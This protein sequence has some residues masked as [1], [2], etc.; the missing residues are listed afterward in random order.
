M[1][2][3][4]EQERIE[5][6]TQL[7]I[8]VAVVRDHP[9]NTFNLYMLSDLH[10]G[11][12]DC[13]YP[14]LQKAIKM[15]EADKKA[16]VILGGDT[17]EAIPRGY[18]INE[19]GQHCSINTQI[20]RTVKEFERIKKKIV[21]LFKGNHNSMARGESIDSDFLIA[22]ALG[23]PYKTVPSMIHINTPTGIVKLAGGHGKSSGKNNDIEL[24]QI[25]K[26]YPNA[27]AYF[28]GHTHA[29]YCK[30]SGALVYDEKGQERWDPVWLIRTGNFLNY[31]DY[32]RYAMY[33]PQRSGFV[34]LSVRKDVIISGR[35]LTEHDE[36]EIIG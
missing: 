12:M 32:A 35:T 5:G 1:L 21:V 17:I 16:L 8:N 9:T 34:Q 13:N 4:Y 19:E 15:I 6:T 18:K 23:I 20:A 25:R 36:K 10:C 22:Q 26:I 24:E 27:Q 7:P 3:R 33:A 11:A 31:P 2:N 28:L 14:F 30:Q 29:L